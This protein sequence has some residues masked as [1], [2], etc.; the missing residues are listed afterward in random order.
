VAIAF[1]IYGKNGETKTGWLNGVEIGHASLTALAGANLL[2][3]AV[4]KS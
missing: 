2:A 3:V 1:F 4:E